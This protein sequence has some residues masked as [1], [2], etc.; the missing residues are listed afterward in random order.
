MIIIKG[1]QSTSTD[2]GKWLHSPILSW[3]CVWL[4]KERMLYHFPVLY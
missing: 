4:L 3:P 1:A 2:Q